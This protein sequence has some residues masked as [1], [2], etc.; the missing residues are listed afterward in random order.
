MYPPLAP[1][2]LMQTLA[3]RGVKVVPVAAEEYDDGVQRPGGRAAAVVMLTGNPQTRAA[4]ERQGCEVHE[5]DGSE[6][7]VKG[8]GGPTCLTAPILREA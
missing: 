6:I 4:L 8:D 3:E 1:V 7:S 5:Y 2:A